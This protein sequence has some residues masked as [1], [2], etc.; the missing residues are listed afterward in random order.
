M[1]AIVGAGM[2]GLLAGAMFRGE[3]QLYEAAPSLPNNH[4]ALLRFR[5]DV[6]AQYL[7]LQF[8]EV[9]LIKI[10]KPWR[11]PV[12]DA[13]SYSM[14]C[15]G[16][17]TIRSL[18][19]ADG[20]V[21]KRFIADPNF[22]SDLS[23]CQ[24]N[25]ILFGEAISSDFLKAGGRPVIS[26]MPMPLLMKLLDYDRRI[27]FKSC[28]GAVIKVDLE[29]DSDICATIYYPDPDF[30]SSR[31]TLTGSTLQIE[32]P[33]PWAPGREDEVI[34]GWIGQPG[35]TF[36]TFIAPVLE[37]FGLMTKVDRSQWS[38]HKQK[39]AKILPADDHERK[40][41]IMWAT[42]QFG[43]YS[44]GRFAT[45]RPGLLLDDVFHDVH[46][47]QQMLKSSNYDRRF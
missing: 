36:T 44:L 31:A 9:S 3:G 25:P 37:D 12:A 22:I 34:A 29:M 42:D 7:N 35:P 21:S 18:T 8:K 47:I 6:I 30:G 16:K 40:R 39:Y 10:T 33:L 19:S 17:A 46:H 13:I 1:V 5:S 45:W 32:I 4:H 43:I 20:K 24:V 38:I 14:K 27:D 28:G 26:T 15:T 41:F 11:N 2:A 23:H